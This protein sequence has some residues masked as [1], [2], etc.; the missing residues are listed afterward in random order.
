MSKDEVL[1]SLISFGDIKHNVSSFGSGTFVVYAR[2]LDRNVVGSKNY[3]LSF[4]KEKYVGVSVTE[5]LED[6]KP[7]CK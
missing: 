2:F 5:F 7:V 1:N 4:V 6:T 3:N